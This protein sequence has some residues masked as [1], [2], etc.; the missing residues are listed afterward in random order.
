[1]GCFVCNT[2]IDLA[3]QDPE[4]QRNVLNYFDWMRCSFAKALQ[5]AIQQ[6]DLSPD[7]DIDHYAQFLVGTFEGVVVMA[8][9]GANITF[10]D[11]LLK[12]ASTG[13]GLPWEEAPQS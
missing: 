9:A 5:R 10:I 4:V 1:M 3:P 8:R 12:T 7:F 2:A 6:G 11:A 13:L